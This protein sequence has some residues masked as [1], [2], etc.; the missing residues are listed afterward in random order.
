MNKRI[1][2]ISLM[3]IFMG[4]LMTVGGIGGYGQ[5]SDLG[6]KPDILM[7]QNQSKAADPK[8]VEQEQINIT[9]WIKKVNTPTIS[10]FFET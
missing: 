2:S 10:I 9:R 3:L 6:Q 5:H 1:F 4:G 7:A 8:P